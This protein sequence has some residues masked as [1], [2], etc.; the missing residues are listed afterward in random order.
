MEE[1]LK[2]A[3]KY[4]R[5]ENDFRANQ[6]NLGARELFRG[7]VAK[8]WVVQSDECVTFEQ[9]NKVMV[10]MCVILYHEC[11]KNRC[12]VLHEPDAQRKVLENEIEIMMVESS[13]REFKNILRY[14][15]V[16]LINV[17]AASVSKMLS[18]VRSVINVEENAIKCKNQDTRSMLL[19]RI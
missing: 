4:F 1:I 10:V 8:D 15:Q 5:K 12:A 9:H 3:N 2:D 14:V 6:E 16:H 11:W 7:I 17:E 19:A 13:R 18:W